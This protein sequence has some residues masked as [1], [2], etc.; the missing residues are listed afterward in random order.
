MLQ[1]DKK[2]VSGMVQCEHEREYRIE[3]TRQTVRVL[4]RCPKP[5]CNKAFALPYGATDHMATWAKE[6]VEN[7]LEASGFHEKVVLID[8]RFK[9][10]VQP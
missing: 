5:G 3:V 2:V 7:E 9:R 8:R 1:L 10:A 6:L 4:C